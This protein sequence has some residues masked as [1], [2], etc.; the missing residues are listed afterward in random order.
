[1]GHVNIFMTYILISWI[2]IK[3]V[4]FVLSVSLNLVL[5][6]DF[7]DQFSFDMT[8]FVIGLC[9]ERASF[10]GVNDLVKDDF[11]Q[12]DVPRGGG[13][14]PGTSRWLTQIA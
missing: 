4:A 10:Q 12:M 7:G 2:I 11:W 5:I 14:H 3:I 13:I 1:M 9:F 6:L 8:F